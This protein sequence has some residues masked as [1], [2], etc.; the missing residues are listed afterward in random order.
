MVGAVAA[1][2]IVRK[3]RK[4]AKVSFSDVPDG[5]EETAEKS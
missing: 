4:A 3:K 2:L 5:A 1:A